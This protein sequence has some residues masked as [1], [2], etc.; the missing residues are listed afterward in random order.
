MKQQDLSEQDLRQRKHTIHSS[1]TEDTLGEVYLKDSVYIEQL[2]ETQNGDE[3]SS[4][5]HKRAKK[6]LFIKRIYLFVATLWLKLIYG[7]VRWIYSL[8]SSQEKRKEKLPVGG[9]MGCVEE[10]F[11]G[12]SK[13]NRLTRAIKKIWKKR[14]RYYKRIALGL[15]ASFLVYLCYYY[16][17]RYVL[18]S[19]TVR[20]QASGYHRDPF[21]RTVINATKLTI[22]D[23]TSQIDTS[24]IEFIND[25]A[26]S[27]IFR[28][29]PRSN[30]MDGYASVKVPSVTFGLKH[31][32]MEHNV[33]LA[34]LYL[35]MLQRVKKTTPYYG[36]FKTCLCASYYGLPINVMLLA[37][38]ERI[39]RGTLKGDDLLSFKNKLVSDAKKITSEEN[40]KRL[41]QSALL[42][43]IMEY[44]EL[45]F[46]IDPVVRSGS[47][48]V[49]NANL[50][51]VLCIKES[52]T[53][54]F[55][56]TVVVDYTNIFG[57]PYTTKLVDV[58]AMCFARCKQIA[59]KQDLFGKSINKNNEDYTYNTPDPF[60]FVEDD[61][62]I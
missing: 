55:P 5:Q 15:V 32:M 47:K 45:I 27:G 37:D 19:L 13:E 53:V 1:Q 31:N 40:F 3:G 17:K 10:G 38:T 18:L 9:E 50:K 29:I 30:I 11:I 8:R 25:P 44:E 21:Y 61:I 33:S 54:I 43:L 23:K 34:D 22:L 7:S 16:G 20:G 49:R 2:K 14:R 26:A 51:D 6:K 24:V 52:V 4:T 42:K 58:S 12:R 41:R 36:E 56:K 28:P 48:V 62:F 60:V 46:M 39:S 59:H 35:E 57:D